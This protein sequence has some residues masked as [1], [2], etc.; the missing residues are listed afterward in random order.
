MN[1]ARETSLVEIVVTDADPGMLSARLGSSA[2]ITP[3]ASGL[4]IEVSDEKEV[5]A[6]I[7]AL[8]QANGKLIAVQPVRQSLEELFLDEPDPGRSPTVREGSVSSK[9]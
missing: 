3:T 4:R 1:C 8:R 9:Q 2:R 5:D 6:V 7:A